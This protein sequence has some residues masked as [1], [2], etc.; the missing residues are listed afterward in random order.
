VPRPQAP[1]DTVG[2]VRPRLDRHSADVAL[3]APTAQGSDGLPRSQPCEEPGG[4]DAD[5]QWDTMLTRLAI[6]R[7]RHLLADAIGTLE[8]VMP[9]THTPLDATLRNLRSALRRLGVP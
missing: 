8:Q 4:L 3:L 6:D 1:R 7:A 9:T 2:D 5:E